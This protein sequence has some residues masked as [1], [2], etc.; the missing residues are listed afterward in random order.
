V[1]G[2]CLL[3][4]CA[5][6]LP[7]DMRQSGALGI[8]PVQMRYCEAALGPAA[9]DMPIAAYAL[10]C[11]RLSLSCGLHEVGQDFFQVATARLKHEV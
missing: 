6:Y 1:Y 10:L 11:S 2:A 8:L 7:S 9:K 5:A 3:H 4:A